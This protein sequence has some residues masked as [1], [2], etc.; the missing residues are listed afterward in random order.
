MVSGCTKALVALKVGH[1]WGAGGTRVGWVGSTALWE[2]ASTL[3]RTGQAL[4]AL[5]AGRNMTN[6]CNCQAVRCCCVIMSQTVYCVVHVRLQAY[7]DAVADLKRAAELEPNDKGVAGGWQKQRAVFNTDGV[8]ALQSMDFTLVPHC[9]V[10]APITHCTAF[11]LLIG[12]SCVLVLVACS[13]FYM[14]R[15]LLRVCYR[16]AVQPCVHS[17]RRPSFLPQ[18]SWLLC[19]EH[20]V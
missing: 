9:R 18:L 5:G 11:T 7:D 14:Q 2:T 6:L 20:V 13:R 10:S 17:A 15:C 19:V 3:F 8:L 4:A 16:S 1:G 12:A